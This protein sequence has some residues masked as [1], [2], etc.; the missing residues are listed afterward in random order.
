MRQLML[1]VDARVEVWPVR[2]VQSGKAEDRAVLHVKLPL[3]G[4]RRA[5]LSRLLRDEH[6]LTAVEN[7][8]PAE[9]GG[10]LSDCDERALAFSRMSTP[11][12]TRRACGFLPLQ[13]YSLYSSQ[14]PE[15]CKSLSRFC[16]HAYNRLRS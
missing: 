11:V 6:V 4:E 1:I 3:T 2:D 8:Q 9:E 7:G 10:T 12:S 15:A 16:T 5:A 13:K 14:L